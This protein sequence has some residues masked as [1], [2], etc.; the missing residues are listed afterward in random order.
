MDLFANL[1]SA[2]CFDALAE[3]FSL[4]PELVGG[5]DIPIV[6]ELTGGVY[7]GEP[8]GIEDLPTVRPIS[9]PRSTRPKKPPCLPGW[10]DLA[11][12]A[13]TG[14]VGS[15]MNVMNPASCGARKDMGA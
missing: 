2:I 8:R 4:K 5:L 1:R 6:R 9:I 3:A 14:C 12:N 10:F 15:K 7:F 13:T 11:K